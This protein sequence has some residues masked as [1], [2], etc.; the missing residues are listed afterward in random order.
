MSGLEVA[1]IALDN[2]QNESEE[3]VDRSRSVMARVKVGGTPKIEI[4]IA[5]FN[6]APSSSRAFV[7]A[8]WS[9]WGSHK[10]E[11]LQGNPPALLQRGASKN[12]SADSGTHDSHSG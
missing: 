2:G 4:N 11:S 10:T 7:F 3:E 6:V 1:F 12:R 9:A 8:R 5:I